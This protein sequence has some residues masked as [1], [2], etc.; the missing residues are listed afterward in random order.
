MSP[1]PHGNEVT[2]TRKETTFGDAEEDAANQE[3]SEVADQT[4]ASH[5]EA[6]AY[7]DDGEPDSWAEALHHYVAWNFGGDV[8]RE[9]N[10][11]RDVVIQTF[12]TKAS[13]QPDETRV[14]DIGTIEE[15]E[16]TRR[17]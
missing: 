9:E 17:S 13:L 3:T 2:D 8:E 10:G 15:A 6:P 16:P 12:H 11:K 4:H 5:D 7:H 14:A 1:I